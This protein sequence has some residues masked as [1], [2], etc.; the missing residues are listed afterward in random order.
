[1]TFLSM[2]CSGCLELIKVI[3]YTAFSY[4]SVETLCHFRHQTNKKM[5]H[6]VNLLW[7]SIVFP[8]LK[9][10]LSKCHSCIVAN[11]VQLNS[12]SLV[13]KLVHGFI[14]SNV[15]MLCMLLFILFF[16]FYYS[17]QLNLQHYK[18]PNKQ[19]ID[20]KKH[21]FYVDVSKI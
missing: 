2:C 21:K 16:F 1:M 4:I 10:K 13:D 20:W 9:R 15:N 7:S 6:I 3:I 8:A 17:E 12:E 19:S 18:K 11:S 14:Q 5:C